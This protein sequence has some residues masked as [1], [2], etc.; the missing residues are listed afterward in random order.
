MTEQFH[1]CVPPPLKSKFAETD[2]NLCSSSDSMDR[3]PEQRTSPGPTRP[4]SMR[5]TSGRSFTFSDN[6]F[7]ERGSPVLAHTS[8]TYDLTRRNDPAP[9]SILESLMIFNLT[10][11]SPSC[12]L[13]CATIL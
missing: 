3:L 1:Q 8:L 13:P 2:S 5:P 4:S 9:S 6:P 12:A 7:S 10:L 11:R